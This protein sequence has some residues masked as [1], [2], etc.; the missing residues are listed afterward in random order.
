LVW[1]EF[2]GRK[3]FQDSLH[4]CVEP[5]Q[6]ARRCRVAHA[7]V[8]KKLRGIG[9]K[10]DSIAR[11]SIMLHHMPLALVQVATYTQERAPPCSVRQ[12]LLFSIWLCIDS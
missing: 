12:Y 7:L 10:D 6:S 11:L 9:E 4:P 2:S 3:S 5:G 8:C 1:V